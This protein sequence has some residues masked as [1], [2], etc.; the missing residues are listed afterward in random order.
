VCR[1][2]GPQRREQ[3]PWGSVLHQDRGGVCCLGEATGTPY[4]HN[5]HD[6][7]VRPTG[8]VPTRQTHRDRGGSDDVGLG[9]GLR[10][11]RLQEL[12][13]QAKQCLQL[14]DRTSEFYA[15]NALK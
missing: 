2:E 10:P 3:L 1:L 5:D 8:V 6:G 4:H 12:R 9:V 7:S 14:G 15:K 11:L 13:A